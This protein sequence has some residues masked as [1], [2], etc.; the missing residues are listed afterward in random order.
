[1]SKVGE[2]YEKAYRIGEHHA[3]NG[4]TIMTAKQFVETYFP[5]EDNSIEFVEYGITR[6]EI[7]SVY[8]KGYRAQVHSLQ[9]ASK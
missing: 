6:S 8:A 2:I 7:Q 4:K 3:R 5:G 1:M 9:G